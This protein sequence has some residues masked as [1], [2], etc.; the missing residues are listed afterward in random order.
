[1]TVTWKLREDVFWADGE[2]VTA[3]DVVFTWDAMVDAGA[4][5]AP[6]DYTE[7]VEKIDD[8]TF[9]VTFITVFPAYNFSLAGK[10]SSSIPST[11]VTLRRVSTNG[12][13]MI[14]P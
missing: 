1:M 2:Q 10:I 14:N 3:D 4:W 9:L 11:T 13:A 6:M 5:N 12:I 8:F 7:S